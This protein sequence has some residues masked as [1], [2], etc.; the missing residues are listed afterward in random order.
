MKF[1][2]IRQ[3][4]LLLRRVGIKPISVDSLSIFDSTYAQVL[5][6]NLEA[7]RPL[8]PLSTPRNILFPL[9]LYAV[10][11][12]N[13]KVIRATASFSNRNIGNSI[14]DRASLIHVDKPQVKHLTQGKAGEGE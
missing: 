10:V 5:V 7:S 11:L 9:L 3:Q 6:L 4:Q 2:L 1:D 12:I 14:L 13:S 8:S